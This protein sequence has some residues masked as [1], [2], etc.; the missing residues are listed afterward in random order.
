MMENQTEKKMENDI[1][2]GIRMTEKWKMQ[3]KLLELLFFTT[4]R[5]FD[6]LELLFRVEGFGIGGGRTL[7]R[8]LGWV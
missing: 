8:M 2:L 4:P 3:W 1:G 7:G 5:T 6:V